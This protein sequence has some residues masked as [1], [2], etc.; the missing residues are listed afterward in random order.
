MVKGQFPFP[1]PLTVEFDSGSIQSGNTLRSTH[2]LINSI[3]PLNWWLNKGTKP[4]PL[5]EK[6]TGWTRS[7]D[8]EPWI[9]SHWKG[10]NSLVCFVR[11]W[12]VVGLMIWDFWVNSG[13]IINK[14]KWTTSNYIDGLSIWSSVLFRTSYNFQDKLQFEGDN[15][16]WVK[17][18]GWIFE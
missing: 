11:V 15:N 18:P 12:K 8:W 13:Y 4:V 17:F 16:F 1:L 7:K 5:G 6:W 10:S 2:R 9:R 3:R 14:W